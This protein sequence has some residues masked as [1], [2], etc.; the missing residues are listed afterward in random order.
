[1]FPS[2]DIEPMLLLHVNATM[3]FLKKTLLVIMISVLI[4][5]QSLLF[6]IITTGTVNVVHSNMFCKDKVARLVKT[7]LYKKNDLF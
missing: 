6:I 1:M 7:K 5:R 2:S 3:L 4:M